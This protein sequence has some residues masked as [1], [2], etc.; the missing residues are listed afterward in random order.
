MASFGFSC[1]VFGSTSRADIVT[2]TGDRVTT[3]IVFNSTVRTGDKTRSAVQMS[4]PLNHEE[5]GA[6]LCAVCHACV[7]Q[8]RE[9]PKVALNP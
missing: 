4:M 8:M 7:T 2:G 9:G 3:F 1:T 6:L 5:S